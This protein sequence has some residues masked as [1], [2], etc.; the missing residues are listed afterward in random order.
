MI[1]TGNHEVENS[2]YYNYMNF[3]DFA[4]P[5]GER[6]YSFRL[7]PIQLIAVNSNTQGDGQ[8]N[9]LADKLAAAETND[10]VDWVIV[11]SHHPGH[12]ELWPDGN[13][14]WVQDSVIPLL[15]QH[16]KVC[17]LY[18]G[19]SHCL[20]FGVHPDAP[21]HLLLS[22]GGGAKLDRWGMY[23]N[24]QDYAEITKTL[25]YYGYTVFDFDL[26][27]RSYTAETYSL[28][29]SDK[30]LNNVLVDEFYQK[31]TN[32]AP[33]KKPYG[34]A[35]EGDVALPVVLTAGPYCG[36]EGLMSSE[37][38]VTATPGDYSSPIVDVRRDLENVYG[39]TGAP[40]Y[41]PINLNEGIDLTR[42]SVSNGLS[43]GQTYAWRV[44][45]RDENLQ[46]SDW[47]QEQTF[48]ITSSTSR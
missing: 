39:T 12:T 19:H 48:M 17:G 14:S 35:P 24:Q 44:R 7:G 4:G 10:A 28:G 21:F 2:Y 13:N 36:A 22:G 8:L 32:T 42:L 47:S 18:Y 16:R 11:Y 46:W 5:E 37:F 15:A 45:Y 34:L 38:Q 27:A 31:R 40:D 41:D 9:W 26:D 30:P 43:V 3:E 20:E 6:Y 33:P 1:C 23:T 25:D 29:N